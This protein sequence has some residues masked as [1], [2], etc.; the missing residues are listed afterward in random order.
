MEDSRYALHET[1]SRQLRPQAALKTAAPHSL[2]GGARP[3]TSSIS[4]HNYIKHG[5][6]KNHRPSAACAR[7]PFH[8]KSVTGTITAVAAR[9]PV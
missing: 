6:F 1:C 4:G 5:S 3:K 8:L 7:H 9:Q 2:L